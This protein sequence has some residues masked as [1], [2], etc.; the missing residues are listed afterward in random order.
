MATLLQPDMTALV[1]SVMDRQAL[2]RVVGAGRRLPQQYDHSF[3]LTRVEGPRWV[4]ANPDGVLTI[5]N[6]A[7]EEVVP[8]VAGQ[9]FPEVGRPHYVFVNADEAWLAPLRARAAELADLHGGA[10]APPAPGGT[11]AGSTAQWLYADTSHPRFGTA[12]D[13]S[14]LGMPGCHHVQ[15]AVGI[16]LEAD[17][18]GPGTWC[19]IE[20]VADNDISG[21][22]AEKREGAGRD[23][24]LSS[25]AASPTGAPALFRMAYESW[26]TAVEPHRMFDG[27]SALPEVMR[28]IAESGLEPP[29]FS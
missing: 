18:A 26:E 15:G 28:A 6:L 24:R 29:A 3:L 4:V 8:L 13:A 10:R 27:P 19:F 22:K 20:R 9:P 16:F 7:D 1:P 25:L 23:P 5:D 21:W 2:I 17:L 14:R 11:A 12:I